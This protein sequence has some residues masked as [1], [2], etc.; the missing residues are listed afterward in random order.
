MARLRTD[1]L[2]ISMLTIETVSGCGVMPPSQAR[3][4]GFN[5][6][7][8]TLPVSMVYTETPTLP[9]R[10]PDIHTAVEQYKHF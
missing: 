8:F 10:F 1:F 4:V 2:V 3:T 5:V 7:G 9:V 6:T